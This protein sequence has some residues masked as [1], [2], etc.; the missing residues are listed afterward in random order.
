MCVERVK[1]PRSTTAAPAGLHLKGTSM[2]FDTTPVI[3]AKG[4]EI[5]QIGLGTWQLSGDVLAKAVGAAI[6]VGCRHFDTATRYSNEAELGGL[7]RGSCLR[8]D[9]YFLTTKVWHTDIGAENLLRSA[10]RSIEL[11]GVGPV[12]LLL[13][14]WPNP[15]IPL[16]ESIGALCKAQ[17]EG[18]TRHIGVS[19]FPLRLLEEAIGLA[20][21]P[22]IANQCESH[23]WLDQTV[24]IDG[25]QRND[26]AFVAHSPIG[27]GRL[28]A[29]PVICEIA[30]A[31]GKSPAQIILRWHLQQGVTLIPRSSSPVRVH[32]N[33]SLSDF[34]LS[35]EDMMRLHGLA[36]PDGRKSNPDWIRGWD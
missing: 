2:P 22:L 20:D 27:S 15:E 26:V 13:I 29:D 33:F 14:H 12:D 8:R 1:L 9:A 30:A 7:L 18:L 34:A 10:E 28:L 19:N 21:L 6:E 17:K 4:V 5:P 31:Y 35:P 23:P 36:R 3:I 11:L 16:A 32:E 24:L 25:C